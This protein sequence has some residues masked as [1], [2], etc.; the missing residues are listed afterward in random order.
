MKFNYKNT[1]QYK[2][3]IKL[4]KLFLLLSITFFGVFFLLFIG[5]YLIIRKEST[6][7]ALTV[8][9]AGIFLYLL[10]DS[11]FIFETIIVK[12]NINLTL[13]Y[14]D[15]AYIFQIKFSECN[16]HWFFQS[17]FSLSFEYKGEIK[18]LITSRIY[19][20]NNL[21]NSLVEVGYIESLDKIFVI[22]KC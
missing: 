9:S 14:A 11:P 17:K 7:I 21:E 18:T 20:S 6:E 16:N 10:I 5:L 15:E 12:H 4:F 22:K 3:D 8:S 1:I 2:E 13:K 19:D